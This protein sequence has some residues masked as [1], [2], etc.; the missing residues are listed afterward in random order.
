MHFFALLLFVLVV[1]LQAADAYLTLR[2]LAA[3]GRELNPVTRFLMLKL[4]SALG[5]AAAKMLA[6]IMVALFLLEHV[7]LMLLLV[8][9]Y[10]WVVR[11]NWN[12]L[13]RPRK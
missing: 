1:L 6:T 3:G 4:N 2:I 10:T 9:L 13:H 8:A 12:Q 5:L 11:Q 7:V